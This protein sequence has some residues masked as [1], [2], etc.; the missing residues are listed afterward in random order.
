L[1][2]VYTTT[3][4]STLAKVPINDPKYWQERAEG[5]RTLADEMTDPDSKHRMLKI[6]EVYEQL[7]R[8]AEQ[9]LRRST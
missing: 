6:A 8:H 5:A 1:W 7:A 9:R 3:S 2:F 4:V